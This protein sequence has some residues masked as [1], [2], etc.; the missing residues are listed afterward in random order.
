MDKKNVVLLGASNSRVP[1]GLEAGLNQDNINFTNLSLGS[2]S[3]LHKLYCLQ[4]NQ[5]IFKKTDLI[6][7]ESNIVDV[8][9]YSELDSRIAINNIIYLYDE[10]IQYK[11]KIIILILFTPGINN[12]NINFI[13]NL[14]K[15][16]ANEYG[17]NVIDVHDIVKN[18]NLNDFYMKPDCH[19]MLSSIM[20]QLGKNIAN[21]ITYFHFPYNKNKQFN[22]QFK[23][24][25]P[26]QLEL[27]NGTRKQNV[28]KYFYTEKATK[29]TK[30][31]LYKI[32][33]KY[34]GFKLIGM[35]AF[36]NTKSKIISKN[37]SLNPSFSYSSLLI[38]NSYSKL[39][40]SACGYNI[41]YD[42]K[43]NIFI[44]NNTT[45]S[46]NQ[47]FEFSEISQMVFKFDNYINT[48]D[49]INLVSLFAIKE[50]PNVIKNIN[51][52]WLYQAEVNI[53]EKYN[54]DHLVPDLLL[55]KESIEEYCI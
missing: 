40:K 35:H 14:H 12:I 20:Y 53:D 41:F 5:E 30:G 24:I 38:S 55:V 16:K 37:I 50:D 7:I 18:N 25:T 46:L 22:H 3:S 45:I 51:Y 15:Y 29:I 11:Q 27:L 34:N 17:Y 9:I 42:I 10:L 52:D 4:K 1:G 2:T 23:I 26:D 39:I 33:N 6:I 31:D 32:P 19:H 36:N 47:N 48:L 28:I 8:F 43:K 49:Y 54:F 44:D 21:N 13:N